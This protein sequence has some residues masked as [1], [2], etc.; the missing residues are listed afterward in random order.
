MKIFITG[1]SGFIGSHLTDRLLR[2]GDE[3]LIID[4]Y[5]TGRRDN[6]KP[7]KNLTIV[8]DT[9]ANETHLAELF[10][11]F[12]P[13]VV[14]HTAASYKDPDNFVEDARTNVLGGALVVKNA[15]RLKVKRLVYFQ[16]ALCYGKPQ[17]QPIPIDHPLNIDMTSYAVS[18]TGGEFYIRMSG[19]DFV[20]FR[21][22][23]VY[24]PRNISGPLPTFFARLTTGKPCFVVDTRRDFVY[25]DDL[26]DIAEMAVDG[27]GPRGEYNVSSGKDCA[28]KELFDMT[29][30]A[31]GITL[32]KEVEVRPRSADDAATIL[33]DPSKTTR[34]FGWKAKTP[35]AEG[36]A[37][38]IAYYR[39][40][41]I[42]QTFTHLRHE[43]EKEGARSGR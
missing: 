4:N 35:L 3:V 5:A 6:L 34:E 31:L 42:T 24:G 37:K 38:A 17:Q 14:V 18:K 19:L 2:R 13:D 36:V 30:N 26:V 39:E 28:I 7:Q 33:L 15:Q 10:D 20:S 29:V 22:A 32:E 16:T 21:L 12:A 8:E 43:H 1:G 11:H 40:F 41:G 23:N 27:K 9:I 25:V